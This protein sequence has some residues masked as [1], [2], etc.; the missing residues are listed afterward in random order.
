V[1]LSRN[2]REF[3]YSDAVVISY[4]QNQEDVVLFR[5][6]QLIP[7]GFYVDVGAAHPFLDNVTYALYKAGWRGINVEPMKPEADLLKELRP[8]D[9][10][11]E[12]AVG[13]A[14]GQVVLHMAPVENRGATT[15]DKDLVAVYTSAGQT[16]E[17][18]EV[19]VVRLDRILE[20][21]KVA[22]VHILKIDVE[23]GERAVLDGVSLVKYR[24][25]VLVIEATKPNSTEDVSSEWEDI[26]LEAGYTLTL[27][28][29]LNKFYVRNDMPEI[30]KLM[31]TPANVFDKWAPFEIDDLT[32]QALR[33]QKTITSMSDNF[34]GELS[35]RDSQFSKAEEYAL[36]IE[37]RAKRAEEYAL[38]LEVRA[39][40]AEEYA[41]SLEKNIDDK[42]IKSAG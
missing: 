19:D 11:Y 30:G 18:F 36:S 34:S 35:A 27:F 39:K 33:L 22:N 5:L 20:E 32:Q 13:N 6:I 10:T 31:S 7:E 21:N 29:G 16:F 14:E 23:G 25:W 28:D 42:N 40:R 37:V 17:E 8:R 9:V 26:V 41:L 2:S 38:S 24:P 12:V 3:C 1:I 15:A 4:S